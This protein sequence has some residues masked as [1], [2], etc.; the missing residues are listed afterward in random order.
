MIEEILAFVLL[1][2]VILY[3]LK[4]HSSERFDKIVYHSNSTRI[5]AMGISLVGSGLIVLGVMMFSSIIILSITESGLFTQ[6]IINNEW[7]TP[8]LMLLTL[9]GALA[10]IFAPFMLW[11]FMPFYGVKELSLRK[12]GDN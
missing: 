7:D 6:T 10:V 9:I 8:I 2:Y 3:F 1:L 4:Q 5:M 12:K 11:S